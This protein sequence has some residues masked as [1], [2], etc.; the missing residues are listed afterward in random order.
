MAIIRI[1]C[2]TVHDFSPKTLRIGLVSIFLSYELILYF[3]YKHLVDE[4]EERI[5]IPLKVGHHRH[6]SETPMLVQHW[7]LV[8]Y[9]CSF[10]IFHGIRTK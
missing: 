7:M 1:L 9:I 2:P 3:W 6:T 10:V 4:G 8:W 5:Q